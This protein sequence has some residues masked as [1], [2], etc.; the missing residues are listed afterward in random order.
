MDPNETPP[1]AASA[2]GVHRLAQG[3]VFATFILLVA[4]GQVTSTESGDAVPTW[5][6]PIELPMFGGAFWELGHRQVAGAVGIVTLLLAIAVE[7]TVRRR[8]GGVSPAVRRLAWAASG[9]V[10]VQAGLGGLRVLVGA[11]DPVRAGTPEESL[12]VRAIA[13]TH[14]CVAQAFL[15]LAV[16]LAESTSRRHLNSPAGV[17]GT[18]R[19]AAAAA[20]AIVFGQILLGAILR[21]TMTGWG[22]ALHVMG[23]SAVLVAAGI[24]AGRVL[25]VSGD[26]ALRRPALT[27]GLALVFQVLLGVASWV[28]VNRGLPRTHVISEQAVI[29][30]LHLV[31]G[32]AILALAHLVF[33]RAGRTGDATAPAPAR[34][35]LV[36]EG[37]L[38]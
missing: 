16:T 5:P 18:V 35:P 8:P 13:I 21:H 24:L 37:S 28:L 14:A 2:R 3:L 6:F 7:I 9:L 19:R 32:G 15:L 33:L 22:L 34:A 27:L 30:T 25:G 17:Q 26:D 1:A 29:P 20:V 36:A 4:G 12:T 23:A 31:L 38:P 11:A 10:L